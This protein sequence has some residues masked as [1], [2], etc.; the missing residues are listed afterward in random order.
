VIRGLGA[1]AAVLVAGC[2][3]RATARSGPSLPPAVRILAAELDSV[4]HGAE[5]SRSLWGVVV[6]SL[7]DGSTLYQRN[8]DLLFKPASNQKLVTGAAALASLGAGFRWR[9][10]VIATGPVRGDTLSGDLLVAGR[11]DP[12]WSQRVAGGAD[13]LAALRPWAD[14]LRSRGVRVV[15]GTIAGDASWFTD[16]PFGEGW[17]WDDLPY[18]YNAPVGALTF[19]EGVAIVEVRPGEAVGAPASATLFPASAPLRLFVTALTVPAADSATARIEWTRGFAS[20]SVPIG[21]TIRLGRAP[22]RLAVAVNDATAYT[23]AALG[24]VLRESGITVAGNRRGSAAPERGDTLFVW[25]SPPLSEVLAH[26]QKTSQNQIGE[27]LLRTMGGVLRGRASAD[28]GRAVV[29]AF[30]RSLGITDDAYR[31]ADGSGSSHYNYL[32]PDVLARILTAMARGPDSSVFVNSLPVA[33]VDGTLQN[34]MRGTA[35]QGNV[36]AK[37]GE[38]SGA[39]NLSG[40]VTTRDGERLVFVLLANHFTFSSR[41]VENAQDRIL[42]RLANFSRR[43]R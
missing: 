9:T 41:V 22:L 16:G 25:N 43:E 28:S 11:G 4:L 15:A 17:M 12:T 37:T 26:F 32:T 8:A 30:L 6:R 13:I 40:Y 21:G 27:A 29:Q 31:V 5:F 3:A 18:Y 20:D 38:I 24:Q 35:A 2:S 10:P 14:S 42:E 36:R 39:R 33:G 1:L 7:D 23:V 34:R 19:N